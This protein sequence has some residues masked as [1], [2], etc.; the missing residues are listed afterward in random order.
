ML[1]I[2]FVCNAYT[3]GSGLAS[4]MIY[5][6]LVW[7]IVYINIWNIWQVYSLRT[8]V[9]R[10]TFQCLIVYALCY[11]YGLGLPEQALGWLPLPFEIGLNLLN[12]A[13]PLE[14]C[15]DNMNANASGLEFDNCCVSVHTLLN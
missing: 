12:L 4:H 14:I 1:S 9:L 10:D 5:T 2:A 6:W 13:L 15:A 7:L 8:Q 3:C 11:I